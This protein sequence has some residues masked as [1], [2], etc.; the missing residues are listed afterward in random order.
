MRPWV[1]KL[2]QPMASIFEAESNSSG[3][4]QKIYLFKQ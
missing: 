3:F 4:S 1:A 2:P